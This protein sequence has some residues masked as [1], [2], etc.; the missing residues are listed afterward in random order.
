MLIDKHLFP[1]FHS[2]FVIRNF[3]SV[4]LKVCGTNPF[5]AIVKGKG[6]KRPK[7]R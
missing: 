5:V 4:V 1:F 7:V 2:L 3:R 6:A